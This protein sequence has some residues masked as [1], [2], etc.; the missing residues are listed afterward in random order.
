M[1]IIKINK[2][3]LRVIIIAFILFLNLSYKAE[4]LKSAQQDL[5]LKRRESAF[6][7]QIQSHLKRIINGYYRNESYIINVKSHIARV[8]DRVDIKKDNTRRGEEM[9][10]PA[11][12]VSASYNR[13]ETRQISNE[14]LTLTDR[15][16]L[17]SLEVSVLVD[18]SVFS[19]KDITFIEK[20]IKMH[21]DIDVIGGDRI[22]VIPLSF[23]VS[24]ESVKLMQNEGAVSEIET[25]FKKILP[26]NYMGWVILF[27]LIIVTIILQL[28]S[29]RK[30]KKDI[31]GMTPAYS[32]LGKGAVPPQL[33]SNM[34]ETPDKASAL[35]EIE[36][37]KLTVKEE[38]FST[39]NKPVLENTRDLFYELRQLMV[40]TLIGNP[41][42]S[43]K[44]F[45]KWV[46]IN[47]DEDIYKLAAFFKATDTKLIDFLSEY[48]GKE[49]TAKVEFAVN[50]IQTIDK[51]SITEIF[52]KFREEF[53]N[54]QSISLMKKRS[55]EGDMFHF[56]KQLSPHQ[57]FQLIKDE[58][59]GIIAVVIAQV[60][61]DIANEVIKNL[62]KETKL[63]IPV[64]IGKLKRIPI[65]SY[66]DIARK[67]SK[68]A[69]ELDK[70][71]YVKTDGI[72]TLVEMLEKSPP[73]LEEELLASVAVQDIT[74][75]EELRKQYIT[76]DELVKMP[77]NI[78]AQVLRDID[79]DEIIMSLI[80]SKDEIRDKIL[81]NLPQ[82]AKMMVADAIE[83]EPEQLSVEDVAKARHSITRRF[84]DMAKSGKLDIAKYMT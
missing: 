72:S 16:K 6:S 42:L 25:I 24:A 48:L 73:E 51:D 75:A 10:L 68:K 44:I 66:T 31:H 22:S 3:S 65:S 54:E 80:D 64:E 8:S 45:M 36:E 59:I 74:M 13:N 33:Y 50:Q 78:F 27:I 62:P 18:E 61:A 63:R 43:S 55:E 9:I 79:R 4:E 23:P 21:P 71:K 14:I 70:I 11:L 46:D 1:S 60:P 82:K 15:F 81:S 28:M 84:R 17:K 29:L 40:T 56:L 57:V 41:E 83:A 2:F 58:P 5:E 49:L 19:D 53:Q 7:E 30:Y 77:D 32:G 52:K 76:F 67:L 35:P 37:K 38:S 34:L 47:K 20:V 12:P 69:M 26:Q 39:E